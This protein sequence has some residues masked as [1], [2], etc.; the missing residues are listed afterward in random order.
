MST[1]V[2]FWEGMTTQLVTVTEFSDGTSMVEL[3]GL[4]EAGTGCLHAFAENVKTSSIAGQIFPMSDVGQFDF[5]LGLSLLR[6]GAKIRRKAW[7]PQ[8]PS[9]ILKDGLLFAINDK[10]DTYQVATLRNECVMGLDWVV[11]E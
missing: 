4:V 1:E 2:K 7:A 11:V 5:A 8:H 6:A 9:M 10:G 3:Q